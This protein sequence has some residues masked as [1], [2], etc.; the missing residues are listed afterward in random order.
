[1]DRTRLTCS[2]SVTVSHCDGYYK[3]YVSTNLK[4][5]VLVLN[6]MIQLRWLFFK[7]RDVSIFDSEVL[8]LKCC[9]GPLIVGQAIYQKHFSP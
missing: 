1:M 9:A 3:Q 7:P 5:M 4:T 8:N 6:Q 2:D